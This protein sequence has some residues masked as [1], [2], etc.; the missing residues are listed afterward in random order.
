MTIGD[1]VDDAPQHVTRIRRGA[2]AQPR[3]CAASSGNGRYPAGARLR[4]EFAVRKQPVM[5]ALRRLSAD[6]LVEIVLQIGSLVAVHESRE[7]TDFPPVF[8]GFEGAI[9][10]IVAGR[11]TDSPLAELD[12]I[13]LLIDALRHD[14]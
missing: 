4:T 6:G 2:D 12:L 8:S 11:R 13:S 1:S 10:G 7:T 14:C 9:A 5:E 3:P